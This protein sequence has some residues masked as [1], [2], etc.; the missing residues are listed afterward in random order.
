M[1]C[2]GCKLPATLLM[3]SEALL[4]NGKIALSK[5]AT[6]ASMPSDNLDYMVEVDLSVLV[7]PRLYTDS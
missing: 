4:V 6:G 7:L 3:S 2:T 1:P 5:G